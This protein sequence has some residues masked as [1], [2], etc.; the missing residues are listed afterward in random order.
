MSNKITA[1]IGDKQITIE[2]GKLA[3]QAD[4]A[5]TVQIG[6]TIVLSLIHISSSPG[7]SSRA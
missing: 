3:K 5:V 1:A 7:N 2:T 6:E 4:G